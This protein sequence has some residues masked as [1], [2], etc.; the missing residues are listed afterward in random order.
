VCPR[1]L[2]L[3]AILP[4]AAL[5][6]GPVTIPSPHS[7]PFSKV[8]HGR[9]GRC[10]DRVLGAE[11]ATRDRGRSRLGASPLLL[12]SRR[13]CSPGQFVEDFMLAP[14]VACLRQTFPTP[15]HVRW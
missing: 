5:A 13:W 14:L 9:P 2:Y 1:E 3:K 7:G 8:V 10:E 12:G 15:R 11:I 6:S 4:L